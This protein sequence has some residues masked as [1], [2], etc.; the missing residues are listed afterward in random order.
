GFYNGHSRIAL[1]VLTMDESESIDEDFFRRRLGRAVELRRDWLKLDAVTD[2]YRLV[3]SEG[4]GLSGLVADR[5]GGT[6]V[7]EFFAA[8][9]WRFRETIQRVLGESFP[10]SR[11]Y[12]FA[13]EH[14]GKQESFD[15]RPPEPPPP[16]AIVE[17][18]VKFRVAPGS[19][20]K[21]GF[22]LDQ[23]DNRQTLAVFCPGRRVLDLCCNT[24]GFAV[25]AKVLGG[26]EEVV[27]VDLDEDDLDLAKLNAHLNQA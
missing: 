26:A 24:G 17:H 22:F 20:H 9:M 14:V 10:E 16:G 18:G 13:E 11:F 1:R 19:K 4:D 15:C 3:H 2:A 12:W 27:A 5:F 23:R 7:L 25:H 6:I 8:G 21:T